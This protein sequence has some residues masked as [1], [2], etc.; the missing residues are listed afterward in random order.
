M[1]AIIWS[2]ALLDNNGRN[3]VSCAYLF[4]LCMLD[5]Y[6]VLGILLKPTITA[7]FQVIS[8]SACELMICRSRCSSDSKK[9]DGMIDGT[10]IEVGI[11]IG[12]GHETV[13]I[14][15]QKFEPQNGHGPVAV[16]ALRHCTGSSRARSRYRSRQSS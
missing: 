7:D 10:G 8:S 12:T 6:K 2:L 15:R 3:L 16:H 5:L 4:R 11:W 9:K 1:D 14:S 13:A